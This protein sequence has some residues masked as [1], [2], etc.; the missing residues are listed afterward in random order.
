MTP[1]KTKLVVPFVVCLLACVTGCGDADPGGADG[2]G[3]G[4]ADGGEQCTAHE[5][6]TRFVVECGGGDDELADCER[7]FSGTDCEMTEEMCEGIVAAAD[8]DEM[9]VY[10]GPYEDSWIGGDVTATCDD[11]CV[12][13]EECHEAYP[14]MD[15]DDCGDYSTADGNT[16]VPEC[17]I[18]PDVTGQ[19]GDLAVPLSDFG[20]CQLD[21]FF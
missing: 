20:C 17:E 11:F 14:E 3:D 4:G 1:F 2:G 7:G 15:E 21:Y 19:L 16:C 6:C 13:C 12:K 9:M 8:C 10:M 5:M 18:D